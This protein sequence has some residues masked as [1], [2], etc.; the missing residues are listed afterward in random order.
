M[1][2]ALFEKSGVPYI[3]FER[4]SSLKPMGNVPA[5]THKLLILETTHSENTFLSR[6]PPSHSSFFY[7][8]IGSAMAVGPTLLPIFQQLGIYEEF[9][10]IGKYLTH[11]PSC[12]ESNEI[13]YPQR[14]TDFRPIEEL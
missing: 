14:A 5:R 6:E 2:G 12:K 1:L 9:I 8:Y 7:G 13:L 3:I 4:S 11:I 10:S